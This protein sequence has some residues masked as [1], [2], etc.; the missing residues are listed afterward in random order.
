LSTTNSAFVATTGAAL[1]GSAVV[2]AGAIVALTEDAANVEIN[3][4]GSARLDTMANANL[5][6]AGYAKNGACS[7]A[8]TGT[9]PVT[10]S[11][12]DLTSNSDFSAGDAVFASWKLLVF[13]NTGAASLTVKTAASNGATLPLNGTSPTITV[14]AGSKAILENAA[15]VTVDATH[16]DITVTPADDGGFAVCVGGA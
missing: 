2:A 13:Y 6:T 16:K 5:A 7:V 10:L 8:L 3:A 14:P 9:T 11:L 15:G 12:I 1:V 4:G